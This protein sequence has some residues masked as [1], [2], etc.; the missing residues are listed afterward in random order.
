V[1]IDN[2]FYIGGRATV[3]YSENVPG[4]PKL[5]KINRFQ[6]VYLCYFITFVY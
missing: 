6:L 3:L 1:L 4:T 5:V 2:I